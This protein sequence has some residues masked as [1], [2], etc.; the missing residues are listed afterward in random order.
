[1]CGHTQNKCDSKDMSSVPRLITDIKKMWTQDLG[2][3]YFE[4]ISNSEPKC[5][6]MVMSKK[7]WTT[8]Y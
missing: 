2:V 6:K 7:G 5:L 4:K 8:T 3:D 1:M